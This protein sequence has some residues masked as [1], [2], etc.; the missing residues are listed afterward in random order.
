[1]IGT[2]RLPL[3]AAALLS[4]TAPAQAAPDTS[5]ARV[6]IGYDRN[7]LTSASGRKLV[8]ARIDAA[9]ARMCGE[10]VFFDRDEAEALAVCRTEARAAV[11]PQYQAALNRAQQPIASR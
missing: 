7:E 3:V 8:L 4:L 9:I 1:M 2:I 11:M 5:T 10:R 6:S